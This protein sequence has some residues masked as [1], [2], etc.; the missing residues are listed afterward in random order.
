MVVAVVLRWQEGNGDFF[1]PEIN[2]QRANQRKSIWLDA[3][4]MRSGCAADAQRA[5]SVMTAVVEA[6]YDAAPKSPEDSADVRID[7][8]GMG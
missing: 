7:Y 5:R 4:W 3:Q 8:Q 6:A 2:Q 1:P